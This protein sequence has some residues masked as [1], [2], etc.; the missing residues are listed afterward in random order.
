MG[1]KKSKPALDIET[2]ISSDSSIWT[3]LSKRSFVTPYLPLIQITD[4]LIICVPLISEWTK[5]Y[6][7]ICAY[8]INKNIW[9]KLVKFP[10]DLRSDLS[11]AQT[12]VSRL[13]HSYAY[14]KRTNTLYIIWTFFKTSI[15]SK[16]RCMI[17][18]NTRT[19][20]WKSYDISSNFNIKFQN[21][22]PDFR[23]RVPRLIIFENELHL[24]VPE[25]TLS[26]YKWNQK[27]EK[28]V[29]VWSEPFPI[30]VIGYFQLIHIKTR[31]V[32]WLI[33]TQQYGCDWQ[34]NISNN[35]WICFDKSILYGYERFNCMA[36]SVITNDDKYIIWFPVPYDKKCLLVYDINL[37]CYFDTTVEYPNPKGYMNHTV[38]RTAIIINDSNK[39]SLLCYGF[40]RKIGCIISIS[41]DI[42]HLISEM[43]CTQYI[44]MMNANGDLYR[45]S[46]EQVLNKIVPKRTKSHQIPQTKTYQS[47]PKGI[48]A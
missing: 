22:G 9:I 11:M 13:Q 45:I 48:I 17:Q 39:S 19:L 41:N 14:N 16:I 5:F 12:N 27:S 31:N 10:K 47:Y 8:N 42:I 3:F 37:K 6:N 36:Y 18:F 35:K 26:H 33:N 30:T 4:N 43:Y 1:N 29:L 44:Y 32:I 40:I 38:Y 25:D 21:V 46:V 28:F 2:G 20:K 34:Y 24:M 7:G 23:L 15:Q